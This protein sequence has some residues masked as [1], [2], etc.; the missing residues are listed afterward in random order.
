M[1]A[2]R[3][4]LNEFK[5]FSSVRVP[6]FSCPTG[7]N[8]TLTSTRSSPFSISQLDAPT[9]RINRLISV[10]YAYA[11]SGER[12]SGIETISKSGLPERLK[13]TSEWS[14]KCVDLAASSSKCAWWIPMRFFC[15]LSLGPKV[16]STY[17]APLIGSSYW[18]IWYPFG[19][20]G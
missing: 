2:S 3:T 7:R 8:D 19:K 12:I 20:S 10:K 13:S 6:N 5:F 14:A 9:Q 11:S 1:S 4:A 18:V 15:K 16:I 17:P